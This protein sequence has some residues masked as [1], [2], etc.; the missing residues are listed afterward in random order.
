[1]SFDS[2]GRRG[3]PESPPNRGTERGKRKKEIF[4]QWRRIFFWFFLLCW[5]FVLCVVE[6]ERTRRILLIWPVFLFWTERGERRRWNKPKHMRFLAWDRQF[7]VFLAGSRRRDSDFFK[8]S[9]ILR[10]FDLK[11]AFDPV[12]TTPKNKL[13]A[14][15]LFHA[16]IVLLGVCFG[17]RNC[18]QDAKMPWKTIFGFLRV[19][20][21]D[22]SSYFSVFRCSECLNSDFLAD[23][24][25]FGGFCPK[26]C[27]WSTEI[28]S[29]KWI[30]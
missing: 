29:W 13:G 30:L 7:W 14:F 28:D 24:H 23:L 25:I 4:S 16:S 10:V 17:Q 22:F 20:L 11:T 6:R 15:F 2:A 21:V 12:K 9:V 1:M 19:L 18:N 5:V 8:K 26:N 27:L 3:R